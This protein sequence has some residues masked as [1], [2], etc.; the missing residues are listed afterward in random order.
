MEEFLNQVTLIFQKLN[1]QQTLY[2]LK[3]DRKDNY[4]DDVTLL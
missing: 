1:F 3:Q 4:S 2:F